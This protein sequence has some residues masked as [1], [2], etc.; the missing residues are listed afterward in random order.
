MATHD[1]ARDEAIR[2]RVLHGL[3]LNRTPGFHFAGNFLD[4][5]FDHVSSAASRLSLELGPW[6]VDA[7][8]QVDLGTLAMLAD[9]ALA[10]TVRANLERSTR[11]ATVSMS[12]ELT[13]LPRVGRL[14]AAG[15]FH[16]FFRE[17]T[18]RLGQSRV[19]VTGDAGEVAFGNGSFMALRP[20]AG[21]TMHPA[22]NRRRDD[23]LPPALAA[24]ELKRDE[25]GILRQAD[26]ALA[27]VAADGGA[28]VPRFW[29]Y[30]PRRVA[31]GA[32]AVMKN[33]PHV[34]NRVGHAQGGITLGLASATAAAA[35]PPSWALT[36]ISGWYI[37][38]G[39]GTALRARA[40][41]IHHGRLTAVVRTQVTGREKRRVLEVVTTHSCRPAHE[42]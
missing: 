11:L 40:E 39:E 20:P 26:A 22:P 12:L 36:G 21:V 24:T 30:A 38:P 35:L 41:V 4:V 5:S 23:P 19:V 42:R 27:R 16:G 8:G 13:G 32:V 6:C 31:G 28:F 15:E 10:A 7:D 17:G 33:G 18:G 25:L 9:L 3:S 37:S 2:R 1:T 34:G 14:D 29:G